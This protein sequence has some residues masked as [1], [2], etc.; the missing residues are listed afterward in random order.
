MWLKRIRISTSCPCTVSPFVVLNISFAVSNKKKNWPQIRKAS[1]EQVYL[2]LLQNGDF[3]P[4]NKIEE[5]LEIVSNTCWEGDLENAKLQ[6]REL[7]YIAGIETDL[8]PKTNMVPPPEKQVKNR[9]SGADEN[10]SYS[11]LSTGFWKLNPSSGFWGS[12]SFPVGS[13]MSLTIGFLCSIVN[14]SKW[15]KRVFIEVKNCFGK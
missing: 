7:S 4:E 8:H 9:F 5:A 15:G 14:P 11:S 1:A 12:S 13:G 3:V 2:V 10:A 6:R